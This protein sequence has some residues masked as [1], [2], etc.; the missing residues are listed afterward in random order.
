MGMLM[1]RHDPY[2]N[3]HAPE[4][5]STA[6]AHRPA[7]VL[8]SYTVAQLRELA[9]SHDVAITTAMRK[10][11]LIA[12]IN[13][14]WDAALAPGAPSDGDGVNEPTAPTETDDGDDGGGA[15]L[16]D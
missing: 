5:S 4:E 6:L 8:E 14:A 15:S 3:R 1:H 12:A 9:A 7:V 13:A 2:R 10:P 16:T 11:D